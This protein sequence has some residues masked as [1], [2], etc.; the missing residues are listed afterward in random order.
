MGIETRL[1]DLERLVAGMRGRRFAN[2]DRIQSRQVS[3]T[4]P[5]DLDVL[6]WNDTTKKY[7]PEA[8]STAVAHALDSAHHTD[9]PTI[10]ET[11]AQLLVQDGSDWKPLAVGSNDKILTAA[12]GETL[13]VKWAAAAGGSHT[14]PD[15]GELTLDAG[16]EITVTGV[17]HTVDTLSD[18]PEDSLVTINGGSDG[19]VIFLAPDNDARTIIL[20]HDAGNISC[21]D[22]YDIYLDNVQDVVMLVYSGAES[23]WFATRFAIPNIQQVLLASHGGT[24]GDAEGARLRNMGIFNFLRGT[25][26]T[27]DAGDGDIVASTSYHLI[28]GAGDAAD[29]LDGISVVGTEVSGQILILQ[30]K[31]GVGTITVRHDV[32][33]IQC[34][35][36]ANFDLD[37]DWSWFWAMYDGSRG[38]WMAMPGFGTAH[39]Y[40]THSGGV[41]FA[42]LEYDDA[43]SDPL[44][45]ADAADDGTEDSAARKDHV[46]IKHHAKY[47]DAAAVSAVAT[48]DAYIKNDGDVGTGVYD[49]G[50]ADSFEIPNSAT[51]TVDAAGEIALD[52]NGAAAD[53]DDAQLIFHDGTREYTVVS[54]R[55]SELTTTDNHVIVYDAAGNRF[56]MEAQAGGGGGGGHTIR[57][58]GSDLTDR[59]GLNFIGGGVQ[60]VDDAGGDESEVYILAQPDKTDLAA[61]ADT[62]PHL[63][64]GG[65]DKGV[66]LNDFV[67]F[68]TDPDTVAYMKCTPPNR[69][70]GTGMGG[71]SLTVILEP[72]AD[73]LSNQGM[74]GQAKIV[75]KAFEGAHTGHTVIGLEYKAFAGPNASDTIG[76][77]VGIRAGLAFGTAAFTSADASGLEVPTPTGGGSNITVTALHG[78]HIKDQSNILG[79]YPDIYGLKID[80]FVQVSGTNKRSI[81]VG[82]ISGAATIARMIELNSDWFIVKG[83]AEWTAAANETPAWLTEGPGPTSRQIKWKDGASIGGGDKVMVLV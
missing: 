28:G 50:G 41:P 60:A 51:P 2:A 66:R 42:E 70:L 68:Q 55:T 79:T 65:T 58:E 7:E 14:F 77:Q 8:P 64:L 19:M 11:K 10:T 67:G 1:D 75:G 6:K 57:N 62:T 36:N 26:L 34:V 78:A 69:Q 53:Y 18:V 15:A 39:D 47:T 27:I 72:E 83:S 25:T 32:D 29:N 61:T 76:L 23:K 35:G 31:A 40:D 38:K 49:F 48:D 20:D 54:V 22:G 5:S 33:N 24:V 17:W 74:F 9:V 45:D 4:A 56:L 80:A 21:P 81:A 16:G 30:R 71:L 63:I 37:E 44:Q 73:S 43:T 52:T 82:D 13:G 46:H 12:S 59:T 3:S